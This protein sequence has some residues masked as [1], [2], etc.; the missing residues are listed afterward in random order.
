M[1][2]RIANYYGLVVW[3]VILI[4]ILYTL[5]RLF[6]I[7]SNYALLEPLTGS[8]I[9]NILFGGLMFDT[10]AILYTNILYL[11]LA[12]I[13][14][15][16]VKTS[17]Y[18]RILKCIYVV[19]N[20]MAI[21]INL[22]DT[23]YFKFTLRRTS[24]TFFS[25]FTGDVKFFKIFAESIQLYWY[26]FVI[27]IA[28]LF[29]LIYLSGSYGKPQNL[30]SRNLSNDIKYYNRKSFGYGF[31]VRQ[32]IAL[33]VVVPVF[34]I[35]VRGGVTRTMKPITISKAGDFTSRAIHASA[36]LN[37]P[38]SLIRTIGK[39]DYTY[40]K[41]YPSYE[42]MESIFSPVH[43]VL[44]SSDS[45]AIK[46]TGES[47]F[48]KNIVILILEGFGYENMHFLNANLG[49]SYTPFLDSL[50]KNALVCTN[51]FANGR[52]SIDAIPSIFLSLPSMLQSYAVTPYSTD[53]TYG[54]PKILDSLGYYTAFFHGAPNTSMGIRAV[55]R[56][57]GIKN[58]YGKDEYNNNSHF[59]GSWGIWDEHFLQYV[60]DEIGKLPQ[61][62]FANIF[63]LSSHHPFK[64]PEEYKDTYSEG[65]P[66]QRVVE[67]TDMA[68]RKFFEKI[69]Q[70]EWFKNTLFVIV[71]DHSTLA[72]IEP[73]FSTTIGNTRIPLLYYAPGYIEPG[74]YSGVTQQIDI[75]PTLLG[76]LDYKEPYFAFGRNLNEKNCSTDTLS[77]VKTL[78][79]FA[80]NY[81]EGQFQLVIG[82]T[83]LFRDN[84]KLKAVYLLNEDPLLQNNLIGEGVAGAEQLRA[85]EQLQKQD[86]WFKAF[87]QQYVNRLIDNRLSNK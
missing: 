76:L 23:V 39:A 55:A 82:D 45:G 10:S 47:A 21:S 56:L 22:A 49:R 62:F 31:Y 6:F 20:F 3:R 50:S 61:P 26:V 73:Q 80:V 51:A 30:Y 69:E 25:E 85:S 19:I 79:Q 54:L 7:I 46:T 68:L 66:M 35:G 29:V 32:V 4:Y 9:M 12:F 38:F 63:T 48:G 5:C 17:L 77:A 11:F 36:V 14:A 2:F 53:Y 58:Y 1:K 42:A 87:I 41:F 71:P 70:K 24:M 74:V 44:C 40:Q 33:V 64:I 37:T 34:I 15:P 27:G 81:T 60:G 83:L 59:D 57:C 67:Y 18:Q 84:E 65:S 8:Q 72:G 16:L 78:P 13:P 86:A 75:M 52:K 43:K 28:F